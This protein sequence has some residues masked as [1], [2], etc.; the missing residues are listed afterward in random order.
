[1]YHEKK[2]TLMLRIGQL[3]HLSNIFE[4]VPNLFWKYQCSHSFLKFEI[5][6]KYILKKKIYNRFY[7]Q[8]ENY[9]KQNLEI[10]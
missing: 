3:L 9:E 5:I 10:F 6:E 1:M 8:K 4:S 2:N 7:F